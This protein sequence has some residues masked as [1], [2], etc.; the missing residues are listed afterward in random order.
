MSRPRPLP[1]PKNDISRAL[2][3]SILMSIGEMFYPGRRDT[4]EARRTWAMDQNFYRKNLVLWSAHWLDNKGVT[5]SP[6]RFK[7]L[8]LDK[9]SEVK[10]KGT[11][12]VKYLPRYLLHCIQDHFKHNGEQIYNEAKSTAAV[13]DNALA[14]CQIAQGGIDPIRML[15]EAYK[16][17]KQPKKPKQTTGKDPQ[18]QL[19]LL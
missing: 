17:S 16:L 5:L 1:R 18:D 4:K 6:E 19:S 9:L 15:S 7:L 10:L 14:R 12:E 3:D 2:M 13:V 8:L 11:S